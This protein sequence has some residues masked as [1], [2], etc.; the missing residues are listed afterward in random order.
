MHKHA[1]TFPPRF[2]QFVETPNAQ[3]ATIVL[4][5]GEFVGHPRNVH[6]EC[7][8]WVYVIAGRGEVIINGE[9][10]P[11]AQND[12]IVIEQH[13]IHEIHNTGDETL[14]TLNIYAP[15]RVDY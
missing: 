9:T 15:L 3:G 8:Q 13:E 12:L 7:D 6:H 5:P 2:N 1:L 14:R 11:F 4:E 10:T